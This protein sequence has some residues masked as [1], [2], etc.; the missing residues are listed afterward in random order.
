MNTNQ[1]GYDKLLTKEEFYLDLI[2]PNIVK[3]AG[4]FYYKEEYARARR[5]GNSIEDVI[6]QTFFYAYKPLARGGKFGKAGGT[7]YD[8]YVENYF[9]VKNGDTEM[10]DIYKTIEENG[11]VRK[12]FVETREELIK[13]RLSTIRRYMNVF[14]RNV[15]VDMCKVAENQKTLVS[16]DTPIGGEEDD[17][18]LY[19][20]FAE[21]ED[22]S[23]SDSL[24]DF[25]V[26]VNDMFIQGGN[27]GAVNVTRILDALESGS[28]V[29]EVAKSVGLTEFDILNFFSEHLDLLKD[30]FISLSGSSETRLV[31]KIRRAK[32]EKECSFT[33][34]SPKE[35][36]SFLSSHSM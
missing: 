16:F 35:L 26:S 25:R 28:S 6:Q 12:E 33:P 14:V 19:D 36:S 29:K 30:C 23:T 10:V 22:T 31:S 17:R 3:S 20:V 18:T 7:I 27:D 11:E 13:P 5:N 24:R 9:H 32:R 15:L 21:R 4:I 1:Y 34:S 2:Y 8:Y